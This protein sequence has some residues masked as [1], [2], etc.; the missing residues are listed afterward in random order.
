MKNEKKQLR[1]EQ[2]PQR[3]VGLAGRWYPCSTS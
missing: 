1:Q 2:L 3:S